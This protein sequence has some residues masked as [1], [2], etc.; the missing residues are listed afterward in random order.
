MDILGVIP[1]RYASTR[2]A[3]KPLADI[4]GKT[5]IQRVWERASACRELSEVIVATDDER[6][7]KHVLGFGGRAVMTSGDHKSGTDRLGEVAEGDARDSYVN[8]QGDEPLLESQAIDMLVQRTLAAGAEMS[9]LVSPFPA[10]EAAAER[11]DPNVV[12]VVRDLQGYALYFSRSAIPYPYHAKEAQYLRHIGVYMYSRDTLLRLCSAAPSPLELA[13]SLEQLR[14][15]QTGV[16]IYTV[17]CDY[18]P[19]A[20]DTPADIELVLRRL[21]AVERAS[22]PANN[23]LGSAG[24]PP[25]KDK[26]A[27]E[28]PALPIFPAGQA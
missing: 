11:Q 2:F 13:E 10:N 14:A 28:T 12:K 27:G 26:M 3:G 18:T 22:P 6:I 4:G 16:R 17:D 5:L 15:L 21:D 8:I 9:T 25:A 20:V 1:A 19:L 24:V 7:L 23:H